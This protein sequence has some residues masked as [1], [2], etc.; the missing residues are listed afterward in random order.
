MTQERMLRAVAGAFILISVGLTYF[1]SAWFFLFTV[2][3]G[4]NLFQSALT[5]WCPMMF[6]LDKAGYKNCS[7]SGN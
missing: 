1:V 5:N 2:F 3:I 4:L 7:C 6:I